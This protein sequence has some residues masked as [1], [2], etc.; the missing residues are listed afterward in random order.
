MPELWLPQGGVNRK[1]KELWL[2]QGGVNRKQKEL[3]AGSGGVNR[4]IF[5]GGVGYTITKVDDYYVKG[6][7]WEDEYNLNFNADGSGKVFAYTHYTGSVTG[8]HYFGADNIWYKIAF[9]A[10]IPVTA[11]QPLISVLNATYDGDFAA[12]TAP[13]GLTVSTNLGVAITKKW[14][15][16]GSPINDCKNVTVNANGSGTIDFILMQYST[17]LRA[18]KNGGIS[19][20][21]LIWPVGAI[22]ILGAPLPAFPAGQLDIQI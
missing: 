7:N 21:W 8:G 2:P 14:G 18:A 16:G 17:S 9:D 20:F 13:L 6:S 1:Q 4:K 22:T 5:S 12:E 11:G 10:P 3:R 15:T 19:S